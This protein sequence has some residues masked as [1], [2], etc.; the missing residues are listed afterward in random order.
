MILSGRVLRSGVC[1]LI[2]VSILAACGGGSSGSS[3]GL[4]GSGSGSGSGSDPG[5][6]SGDDTSSGTILGVATP[7]SVAVV[8]ATN[9]N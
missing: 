8:T 9:A 4:A 7:S 6:G 3:D 2:V 5:S 1:A